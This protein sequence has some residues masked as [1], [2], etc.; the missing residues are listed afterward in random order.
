MTEVLGAAA[1]PANDDDVMSVVTLVAA[2]LGL[3]AHLHAP[4]KLVNEES[5]DSTYTI[6]SSEH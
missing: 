4:E 5:R 2:S 3:P 1:S 6:C